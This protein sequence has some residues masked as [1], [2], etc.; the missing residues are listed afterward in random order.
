VALAVNN[1]AKEKNK[2]YV[3]C[4]AATGDLTGPQCT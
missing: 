2:V 3:N 4:G 1:V